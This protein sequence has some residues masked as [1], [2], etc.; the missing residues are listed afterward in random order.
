MDIAAIPPPPKRERPT[1][2][3]D[4]EKHVME[5]KGLR[6]NGV[7]NSAVF[8]SVANAVMQCFPGKVTC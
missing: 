6:L 5:Y 7:V 1:L 8:I 2:L 4:H 3:G